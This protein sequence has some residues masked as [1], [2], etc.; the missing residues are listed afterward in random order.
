MLIV[1]T[2]L[3]T[4]AAAGP[5]ADGKLSAQYYTSAMLMEPVCFA[6]TTVVSGYL[7]HE[8]DTTIPCLA[9]SAAA[10]PPPAV[11]G[12]RYVLCMCSRA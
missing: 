7:L 9:Q 6:N 1:A 10:T 4:A 11:I 8:K 5:V 2:F 3:A 12:A